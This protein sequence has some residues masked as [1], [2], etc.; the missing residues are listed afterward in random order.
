MLVGIPI[1]RIQQI[2][3]LR[4]RALERTARQALER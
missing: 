3:D 4:L 1:R 2:I